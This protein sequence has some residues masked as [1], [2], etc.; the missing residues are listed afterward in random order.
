MYDNLV[1]YQTYANMRGVTQETVRFWARKGRI[2]TVSI[3]KR[4]FVVLT[5][6]EVKQRQSLF[7]QHPTKG[8]HK[9]SEVMDAMFNGN[10]EH[11]GKTSERNMDTD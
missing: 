9:I 10:T 4:L 2:N 11:Y 5:D 7:S 3:D 6:E 8:L 1:S